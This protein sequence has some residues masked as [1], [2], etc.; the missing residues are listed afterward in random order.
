YREWS[1]VTGW[2]RHLVQLFSTPGETNGYAISVDAAGVSHIVFDDDSHR[3]AR[4]TTVYYMSGQ[5]TT[6]TRPQPVVPQFGLANGRFP[7]VDANGGAVHL[8]LN[9]N[10]GGAYG[11]SGAAHALHSW[12]L[13]RCARRLAL[14]HA[15]H[16]PG[17]A[18][19]HQRL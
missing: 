7:D 17:A 19:R 1:P 12:A 15:G 5:G 11:H 10:A 9:S 4:D 14:L 18:R 13:Q 2:D 16:R 8:V 6:F 3:P